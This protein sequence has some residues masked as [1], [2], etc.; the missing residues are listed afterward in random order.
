MKG[1]FRILIA[2]LPFLLILSCQK[3]KKENAPQKTSVQVNIYPYDSLNYYKFKPGTYWV[4]K[5]SSTATYDTVRVTSNSEYV[6]NYSPCSVHGIVSDTCR[7]YHHFVMNMNSSFFGSNTQLSMCSSYISSGVGEW[8]EN[9]PIYYLNQLGGDSIN[10][11]FIYVHYSN[12]TVSIQSQTFANVTKVK[13]TNSGRNA[14]GA[15]FNAPYGYNNVTFYLSKNIGIIRKEVLMGPS[16][17]DVWE[18][19]AWNIVQ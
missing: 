16:Q 1:V 11:P 19:V 9:Y 10:G 14:L 15:A 7:N 6:C 17:T 8:C 13:A 2:V 4:Y 5:K 18:L 12:A 3:K